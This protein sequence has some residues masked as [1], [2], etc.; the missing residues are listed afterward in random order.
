MPTGRPTSYN[1]GVHAALVSAEKAGLSRRSVAA[2]AGIS[3]RAYWRWLERGRMALEAR[4]AGEE[5]LAE[6]VQYIDLFL[7]TEAARAEWERERLTSLRDDDLKANQWQR[8]AWQLERRMPDEYSLTT[9][10]RHQGEIEHKTKVELPEE[11]QKKMLEAF[12]DMA[13]PKEITDGA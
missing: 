4:E 3:P 13:K 7:E 6:Y 5:V 2:K 10:V 1:Q 9:T 8:E 11:V 12:N